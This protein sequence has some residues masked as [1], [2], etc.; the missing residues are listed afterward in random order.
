MFFKLKFLVALKLLIVKKL[1]KLISFID[2]K[3][4][5]IHVTRKIVH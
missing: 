4:S 1:I 2:L 5:R 3:S